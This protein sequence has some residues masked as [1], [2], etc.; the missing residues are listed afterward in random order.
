MH[1]THG[2]HCERVPLEER[3]SRR[4][5]EDVLSNLTFEKW[6]LHLYLKHFGGVLYNLRERWGEMLSGE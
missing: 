1:A 6:P 4:V 3:G 2:R 5:D